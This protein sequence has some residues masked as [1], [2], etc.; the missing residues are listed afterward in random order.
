MTNYVPRSRGSSG[1]FFIPPHVLP[2]HRNRPVLVMV[3]VPN[4][5]LHLPTEVYFDDSGCQEDREPF[6]MWAGY[7]AAYGFWQR[8]SVQWCRIL[9][10]KPSLTH[11][12]Q[13]KARARRVAPF[14][15]LTQVQ[16]DRREKSLCKLLSDNYGNVV[17]LA[18]KVSNASIK[19]HVKGK[20]K[21]GRAMSPEELKRVS[22]ECLERPHLIALT[23]MVGQISQGH[24]L[25]KQTLP[26]SVYCEERQ[27]DPYQ[28]Q[29]LES[30]KIFK[31]KRKQLGSLGFID[32]K[33]R[34]AAPIHAADMLAWHL[35]Y[36]AKHPT[37]TDDRMWEALGGP[38][39]GVA[40]IDDEYLKRYVSKWNNF[41]PPPLR[42]GE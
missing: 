30:W 25:T 40:E 16:M 7:W 15:T 42:P 8:F 24:T 27:D 4:G 39:V 5:P 23:Y 20:I 13:A 35:N 3:R 34:E 9:D 32:G 31:R 29:M 1:V 2:A 19:Q 28:G 38:K 6:F 37:A 41:N 21:L 10:R 22:P 18:I 36:R 26:V 14:S 33:T 17:P 11:W 12:H